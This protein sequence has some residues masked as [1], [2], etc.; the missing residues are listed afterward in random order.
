M[1]KT[2]ATLG[3]PNLTSKLVIAQQS[4]QADLYCQSLDHKLTPSDNRLGDFADLFLTI[5]QI[6]ISFRLLATSF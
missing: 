6:L 5:Q 3:D 2:L 4:R 1:A